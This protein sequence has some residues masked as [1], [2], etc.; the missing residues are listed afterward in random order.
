QLNQTQN[1]TING[2]TV[3]TDGFLGLA[4]NT[5]GTNTA[6]TQ[7]WTRLLLH[8]DVTQGS[9]VQLGY[10]DWMRNGVTMTGHGDQMYVG[11]RYG[12]SLSAPT[13]AIFQWSDNSATQQGP[14]LMRF[15]FTGS[16]TGVATGEH[17]MIGREIQRLHPAG[18]VG[19]GDWEAANVLGV[20]GQPDERLDLLD[21]TIRLRNFMTLPPIGN[22]TDY[23]S[24]SFENVLVVNPLDGVVHWRQLANW[25][26]GGCDW[27]IQANNDVATCYDPLAGPNCPT[28]QN[29]VSIGTAFPTARLEVIDNVTGPLPLEDVGV[30]VRVGTP[31]PTVI[32]TNSGAAGSGNLAVGVHALGAGA[33][34]SYGVRGF[35]TNSTYK[36]GVFGEANLSSAGAACTEFAAGIYGQSIPVAGCAGNPYAGGWAA[37]F[38]GVGFI[39]AP[40]WVYSD[41]SLKD[42]IQP[43]PDCVNIIDQLAPKTYSF[44]TS[45]FPGVGLPDGLQSGLLSP[46]V[47]QVLPHLVRNVAQ[48]AVLDSLGNELSPAMELK[49]MNYEGLIPYLIGA[50]QEQQQQITAMQQD[51]AACCANDGTTDQRSMSGGTGSSDLKHTDLFI[52]PNPVADLTRLRYTIATPG[53]TRL[54]I[55]D[56]QGRIELLEDAVREVGTFE[57]GWNTEDLVPGTYHC[58]LYVNDTFVVKKAVKVAR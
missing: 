38:N 33:A 42:N 55:T 23:Q 31:A 54:E 51:L 28:N 27:I 29:N 5:S 17:S 14:D 22:Y 50:I 53:R 18:W 9:A 11:Q 10:R 12:G 4:R 58:T 13:D 49:A 6:P 20:A 35:G 21:R 1:S 34:R 39:N 40:F 2:F 7:P 44:R 56:A 46:D 26:G 32:G 41:P 57:Y 16:F 3:P 19:L 25:N 45:D 24:N 36:V 52:I 15:L 48:P 8:D 47:E 30:R 37:W 43:I